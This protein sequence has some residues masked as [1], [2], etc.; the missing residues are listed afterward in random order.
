MRSFYGIFRGMEKLNNSATSTIICT[1]FKGNW[2]HHEVVIKILT[3]F[4]IRITN[5]Y[6]EQFLF[7]I[8]IGEFSH[9]K[10]QIFLF[11]K[12]YWRLRPIIVVGLCVIVHL[13]QGNL[14]CFMLS[15]MDSFHSQV[16]CSTTLELPTLHYPLKKPIAILQD[17]YW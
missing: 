5:S 8:S 14:K 6:C 15:H 1:V 9:H 12:Q 2:K 3:S 7:T 10:I 13:L 11:H 16:Y 4:F 17:H